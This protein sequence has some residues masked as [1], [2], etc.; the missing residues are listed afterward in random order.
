MQYIKLFRVTIVLLVGLL[1][2]SFGFIVIPGH[3]SQQQ[4]L[5]LS[6]ASGPNSADADEVIAR[7]IVVTGDVQGGYYRSCVRN[8]VRSAFVKS[9]FHANKS[10]NLTTFHVHTYAFLFFSF[11]ISSP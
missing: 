8:E 4:L 9:L 11:T 10:K 7:R 1:N 3:S 2:T 5:T 6:A